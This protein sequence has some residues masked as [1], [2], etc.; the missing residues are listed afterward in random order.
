METTPKE[1]RIYETRQG[2]FPFTKWLE[3]LK[4]KKAQSKV[5]VRL[6]RVEQGNLGDH[7]AIG[8]GVYELRIDYGPG[9]RICF[10]QLGTAIVILL[11]G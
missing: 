9:Y 7:R 6:A 8:Q 2:G 10:G 11:C 4:D 3:S 5:R 1:I